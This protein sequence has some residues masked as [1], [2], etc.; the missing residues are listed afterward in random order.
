MAK[1]LKVNVE[2]TDLFGGE[3]NYGWVNRE[4]FLMDE[5]ASDLAIVRK[6]K[7]EMGWNNLSCKKSDI[8]DMIE[9]RRSQACEI[10]FIDFETV[11]GD[12]EDQEMAE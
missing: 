5:N 4:S 10:M 12:E 3:A 8:G 9:L 7:A 6:A 1:K 2:V 11:D